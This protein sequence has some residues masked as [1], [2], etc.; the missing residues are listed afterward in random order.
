MVTG[1][2][3]GVY[4]DAAPV[5]NTQDAGTQAEQT[6]ENVKHVKPSTKAQ[7]KD[8]LD[9][10]A[11]T[12]KN[13]AASKTASENAYKDAQTKKDKASSDYKAA[14]K[15]TAGREDGQRRIFEPGEQPKRQ[16]DRG[17]EG[18]EGS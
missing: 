18:R 14:Q 2:A 13:D 11:E 3:G 16:A 17:A 1:M 10:A 6:V 4:A 8:I 12:L 7:A 15:K 9:K 5:D